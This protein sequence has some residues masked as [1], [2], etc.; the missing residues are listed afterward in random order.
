[1]PAARATAA[2]PSSSALTS[3]TNGAVFLD[4]EVL[5]SVRLRRGGLEPCSKSFVAVRK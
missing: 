1:L 2:V 3:T 4:I 5:L